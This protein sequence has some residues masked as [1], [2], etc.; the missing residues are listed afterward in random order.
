MQNCLKTV[1]MM[2]T[3]IVIA[4]LISIGIQVE[5]GLFIPGCPYLDIVAFARQERMTLFLLLKKRKG[6]ASSLVVVLVTGL[7]VHTFP[8]SGVCLAIL[9]DR[10]ILCLLNINRRVCW[11]TILICTTEKILMVHK[12]LM[13]HRLESYWSLTDQLRCTKRIHFSFDYILV[14]YYRYLV[15]KVNPRIYLFI[16]LKNCKTTLEGD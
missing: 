3:S 8:P 1:S 16:Y 5:K 10:D 15:D 14:L 11:N 7:W 13:N 12:T 4:V 6:G 9:K 2:N